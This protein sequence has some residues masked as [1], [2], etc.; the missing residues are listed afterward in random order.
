MTPPPA[1]TF[2]QLAGDHEMFCAVGDR[3]SR[4]VLGR[5]VAGRL[6]AATTRGPYA[7]VLGL[8]AA[9][10]HRRR[11]PVPP[12]SGYAMTGRIVDEHGKPIANADVLACAA[13]GP[14]VGLAHDLAALEA[15]DARG[16]DRR[17]EG[18]GGHRA[19]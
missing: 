12:K 9:G 19:A 6:A 7:K 1:G 3:S 8:D 11:R 2:T 5:A 18:A 14:C 10:R 17:L 16:A 13:D 15:D 4:R